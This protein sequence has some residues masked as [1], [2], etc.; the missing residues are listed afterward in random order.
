MLREFP[1]LELEV[2]PEEGY[3]Q[4]GEVR[5]GLS[6]L[7]AEYMNSRMSDEEFE[8]VNVE[9]F[10]KVLEA[11]ASPDLLIPT[12]WEDVKRLI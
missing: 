8:R 2:R 4:M 11:I 6:S 7:H 10:R 3:L 1:T 5:L 9:H 12:P